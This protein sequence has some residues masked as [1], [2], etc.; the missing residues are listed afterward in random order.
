MAQFVSGID[1]HPLFSEVS[2]D[3]A[4]FR[5]VDGVEA[6]EFRVT[7]KIDMS[8]RYEFEQPVAAANDLETERAVATVDEQGGGS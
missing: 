2:M 7:L 5:D 4:R 8:A 6:R 3:Y 1:E